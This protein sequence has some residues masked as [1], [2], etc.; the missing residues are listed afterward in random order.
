MARNLKFK[1]YGLTLDEGGWTA[2][3]ASDA[4]DSSDADK[5]RDTKLNGRRCGSS[6]FSA[7]AS[8]PK[9]LIARSIR[10][11]LLSSERFKTKKKE[12]KR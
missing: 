9:G 8:S 10:P 6:T 4:S 5:T 3:D 12:K 1:K 7:T 11:A 2:R